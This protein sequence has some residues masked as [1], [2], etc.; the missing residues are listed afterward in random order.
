MM[1]SLT[2]TPCISRTIHFQTM[3]SKETLLSIKVHFQWYIG[4]CMSKKSK[5]S[6]EKWWHHC[7]L[8]SHISETIHFLTI[9]PKETLISIELWFQ[10]YISWHGLEENILQLKKMLMSAPTW[11]YKVF[12]LKNRLLWY[13]NEVVEVSHFYHK[14]KYECGKSPH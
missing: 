1:L 13:F 6:S 8:W 9:V 12:L 14:L 3:V 10:W 7:G 4:E 2:L 5:N 11:L